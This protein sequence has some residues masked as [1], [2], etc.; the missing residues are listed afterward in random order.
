MKYQLRHAAVYLAA[1]LLAPLGAAKT[2]HVPED[3]PTI[4]AGISAASNGD[5]V[6]VA[7]GTYRERI[8]FKGKSILVRSAGGAQTTIIDGGLAGAVVTFATQEG[9]G[10]IIDGFTIQNGAG[11]GLGL[12]EGGGITVQ[13][14]SPVIRNNI[15][16]DNK[17]GYAGGGI[18]I[19]FGSPTILNN[20]IRR[21]VQ[22]NGIGGGGISTRG[23]SPVIRGNTVIDKAASS[24]GG[25]LAFWASGQPQITNNV[26]MRNRGQEAGGISFVNGGTPLI[27]QNVI[28]LNSGQV[29]G[30]SGVLGTLVNNTIAENTGLTASAIGGYADIN[31]TVENNIFASSSS[32]PLLGCSSN[33]AKVRSNLLFAP[34]GSIA[35]SGCPTFEVADGNRPEDPRFICGSGGNYRLQPSSPAIDSGLSTTA[36]PSLDV[37]GAPRVAT[38]GKGV[39][40]IGAYEFQGPSSLAVSSTALT[41]P[42]QLVGTSSG[43][44]SITLSN[45]GTRRGSFCIVPPGADFQIGTTCGSGLDPATSCSIQVMFKPSREGAR[46]S[47]IGVASDSLNSPLSISLSGSAAN[48]EPQMISME[49]S[50]A[51]INGPEFA[52]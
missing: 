45:T 22:S 29:G 28:A 23:G 11:I 33:N 8:D 51:V 26:I 46:S 3:Q 43:S 13:N 15:I 31:V 24:Y 50:R 1:C 5:E 40:D 49:P 34:N 32:Q 39:I 25:G 37:D 42:T 27:Q 44:Q 36:A 17:V 4:Q 21:N 47:A 2:I 7:P 16:Q 48:P 20:I 41:F 19:G 10:A 52:V 38:Y 6:E 9:S 30:V 12:D 14:A 35:A 18:G